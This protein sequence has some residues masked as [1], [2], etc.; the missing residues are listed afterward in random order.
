VTTVLFLVR[1]AAHDN[2]GGYLAGRSAVTLG[3]AGLAQAERTA[4]R[5][6]RERFSM[7]YTSPRHRTRETAEAIARASQAPPPAVEDDLDEIDFGDWSGRTF[8]DLNTDP[9]WQ[10]WNAV[11]TLAVTPGGETFL[12]VQS[13]VVK[14]IARL[15]ARHP[16]EA[17]VIVSHAD[18]IKA[19]ICHSLGLTLDAWP[20]FDIAPA[21]IS[22]VAVDPWT[23]QVRTLN[24]V[25]H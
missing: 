11:R 25:V 10:R 7:V 13:R 24:E 6:K 17:C 16:D 5:L 23:A 2:L 3:K 20:R 22:T 12:G 8:D 21:S 18:V 4:E 1:H 14:L 15:V 19:A 9:E